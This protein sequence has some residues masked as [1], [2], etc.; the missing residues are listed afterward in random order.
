MA[1]I[2]KLEMAP[3]LSAD[4][5]IT[6][7]KSLFSTKGIHTATGQ[8]LEVTV[9][10]YNTDGGATV[11]TLLRAAD[12]KLAAEIARLGVPQPAAIGNLRLELVTTPDH[13]FAAVQAFRYA[14][15]RYQPTTELRI[16]EGAAAEAISQLAK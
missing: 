4:S 10:E 11:E 1:N 2:T 6:I 9:N 13:Q 14:N 16:L 7:K 12:D 15:L 8:K 3:A 5:R